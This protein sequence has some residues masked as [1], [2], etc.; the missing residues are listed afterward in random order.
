M[1]NT[2]KL[3]L[4]GFVMLTVLLFGENVIAQK[5]KPCYKEYPKET[6]TCDAKS[7]KADCAKKHKNIMAFTSC[8]KDVHGKKFCRCQYL[9]P[10]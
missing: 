4:I 7:C 9:C 6:G 3:S 8:I 10:S 1:K 2:V 5:G